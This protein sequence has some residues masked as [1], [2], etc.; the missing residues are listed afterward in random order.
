M[1]R[2]RIRATG[3][4]NRGLKGR[5]IVGHTIALGTIAAHIARGKSCI[6]RAYPGRS[7]RAS[8]HS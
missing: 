1:D 7:L 8:P 6:Y 3:D 2:A 4:I 5:C